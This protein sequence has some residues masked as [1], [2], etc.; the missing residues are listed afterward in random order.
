MEY[1]EDRSQT[2]AASE[3][4]ESAS[5]DFEC[6]NYYPGMIAEWHDRDEAFREEIFAMEFFGDAECFDTAHP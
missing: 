1:V 5:E 6:L 3:S 4:Q 2:E